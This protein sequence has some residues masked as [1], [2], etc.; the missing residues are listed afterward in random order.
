MRTEKLVRP[1]LPAC[2]LATG[3]Q[4]LVVGG[5]DVATRKVGHLLDAGAQVAVVATAATPKLTALAKAGKIHVS[6]RRFA[7][8][9]VKGRFLV[10]ATTDSKVVNKRVLA[11]CRRHGVLCSASDSNWV[12]GDFVTP[13]ITR[14]GDL[15]VSV[16]TGGRSCSR[17]KIVK[18]RIADMLGTIAE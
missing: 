3:R 8:A 10:F 2:L 9:D 7:A 18:D 6:K 15:V 12:D 16:S 14:V 13:A 1:I 17:A 11:A 4:C 5:G